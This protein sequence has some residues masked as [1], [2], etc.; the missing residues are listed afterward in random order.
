MIVAS[1][2][3]GGG[4]SYLKYNKKLPDTIGKAIGELEEIFHQV[5][6]Q[7]SYF[8]DKLDHQRGKAASSLKGNLKS[9]LELM[10]KSAPVLLNFADV[11]KSFMA[12]IESTDEEGSGF[13][14][15]TGRAEWQYSL[16]TERIDEEIKLDASTMKAAALSFK[17]NIANM[18]ELFT[19]FNQMINEVISETK[20]PWDDYTSIWVEAQ[21]MVKSIMEETKNH[22]EKL[23]KEVKVFVQEM[24]RLDHMASQLN[25]KMNT[26]KKQVT[27]AA[28]RDYTDQFF[29]RLGIGTSRKYYTNDGAVSVKSQH[30]ESL[31]DLID[32]RPSYDVK[33]ESI[34]NPAHSNEI[35]DEDFIELIRQVNTNQKE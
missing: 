25:T 27:A 17:S 24:V 9:H 10:S 15:P 16:S 20:F 33:G 28:G 35:T 29:G 6:K 23:V 1:A 32:N 18:D 30:A 2:G 19:S 7:I 31:G 13:I 4:G 34:N 8:Q 3:G 26:A 21:K 5:F 22:I 12:M 11:M 14:T